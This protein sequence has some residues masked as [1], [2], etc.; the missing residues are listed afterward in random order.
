MRVKLALEK[1]R[2]NSKKK[3]STKILEKVNP[4]RYTD[5]VVKALSTANQLA[6]QKIQAENEPDQ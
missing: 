3:T 4:N 5:R 6:K 1:A 2:L